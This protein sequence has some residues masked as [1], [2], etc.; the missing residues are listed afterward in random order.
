MKPI[1]VEPSEKGQVRRWPDLKVSAAFGRAQ[2][3]TDGSAAALALPDSSL[4]NIDAWEEWGD[5][6]PSIQIARDAKA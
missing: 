3:D 5:L 6:E 2:V 4:N 1:T